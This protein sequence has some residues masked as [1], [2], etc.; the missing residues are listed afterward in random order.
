MRS[1]TEPLRILLVDDDPMLLR[2]MADVL[3]MR[4]FV[5]D[6]AQSGR[7]A[8]EAAATIP[9]AVALVDLRLP[10]MDGLDL[11]SRLHDVNNLTEIVV[12]TGNAS[13]SS[14]VRALREQIFDYLLKPVAPDQ[15]VSTLDRAGERWHRRSAENALA[16]VERRFRALIESATDL[17]TILGDG[18]VVEYASPSYQRAIGREPEWL[19]GRSIFDLV[20]AED[21][22]TLRTAIGE[23]GRLLRHQSTPI[24]LRLKGGDGDW[25]AFLGT[26]RDLRDDPAIRGVVLNARDVTAQE[27]LEAQLRHAQKMEAVGQLA[28]GIAHDF[29][30]LLTVITSYSGMLLSEL[31]DQQALREDV[32]EIELAAL[33][34][35]ALTRQLLAFSRRQVL[36]PHYLELNQVVHDLEKL[37]R[38]LIRED[39]ELI[40]S[41]TS[42][43]TLVYADL[44]QLEQV[45]VN[46]VVNARDAQPQGG[47]I[48]IATST[49]ELDESFTAAKSGGSAGKYV[50]LTVT[51]DG[52]GM[53]EATLA[54]VYE[55]FFTT[56]TGGRGTG[57]GL[58]TVQSIVQHSGG[59]VW[60]YSEVGR[61][62]AF[63]IYLPCAAEVPGAHSAPPIS[64]KAS[65]GTETI[66]LVEDEDHLRAVAS[67]ILRRNGYTVIEARTGP[68]AVE[69]WRELAARIDLVVT[70]M[71]MPDMGGRDLA[72]Y[73]R[74]E[75]PDMPLLFMSGYTEDGAF[76]RG[77]LQPGE[78][79]LEKPF[80]EQGLTRMVRHALGRG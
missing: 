73:L 37:L 36:Q 58:A 49:V 78:T 21:A 31:D 60:C 24:K 66:L 55:P 17:I 33:R 79:Y 67:R 7:R 16:T 40:T 72:N 1:S 50:M 38:R 44:G 74:G 26:V 48:E 64:A 35:A 52:C 2:T 51:D 4:G 70:D 43:S 18:G 19:L 46:L 23:C 10:D 80:G 39:I 20:H 13:V 54:R 47:R 71:V 27:A 56:K 6:I 76:Q 68:E 29:N 25:R 59:H 75:R 15:L 57:L 34:A 63:K 5:P 69:L 65:P 12:L 11:V 32:A 42:E 30:N 77:V 9:P 45:I 62:T 3:E 22:E 14:A 61:G 8:I 28:G 41:S 53:D